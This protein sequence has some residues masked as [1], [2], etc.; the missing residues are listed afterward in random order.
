VAAFQIGAR[1]S[2]DL[3]LFGSLLCAIVDSV[4][5]GIRVIIIKLA[6]IALIVEFDGY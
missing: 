1:R 4:I 5:L 2:D 3:C 6:K